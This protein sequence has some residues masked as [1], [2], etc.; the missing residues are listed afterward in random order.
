MSS[1]SRLV[2]LPL[3]GA[4]GVVIGVIGSFLQAV[5]VSVLPLGVVI[6]LSMAGTAFF[7]LGVSVGRSGAVASVLGWTLGVVSVA[8]PRAAG[9][10]VL[11]ASVRSS[12]WVLGGVM[13]GS[14]ACAWP[15]GL[16]RDPDRRRGQAHR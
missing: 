10:L 5:Q 12:A 2:V 1:S 6:A 13:L 4:L 7:V 16:T 11:T 15:Y 14:A 8:V 3:A 9:D